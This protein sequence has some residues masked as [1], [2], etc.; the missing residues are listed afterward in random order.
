MR[1]FSAYLQRL[2]LCLPLYALIMKCIQAH[3]FYQVHTKPSSYWAP[4]VQRILQLEDHTVIKLS[5]IITH[6]Q[7]LLTIVIID[8]RSTPHDSAVMGNPAC[9]PLG[10]HS[11]HFPAPKAPLQSPG[12]SRE[13]PLIHQALSQGDDDVQK[14]WKKWLKK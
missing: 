11:R 3:G 2:F 8:H 5:T 12:R 4:F 6:Y 13:A 9:P 7:Q 14:R 10:S 1:S